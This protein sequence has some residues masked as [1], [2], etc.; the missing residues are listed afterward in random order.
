MP[1][2]GSETAS[3]DDGR[4]GSAASSIQELSQTGSGNMKILLSLYECIIHTCIQCRYKSDRLDGSVELSFSGT[5]DKTVCSRVDDWNSSYSPFGQA[6][7]I[8]G[9]Q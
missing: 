6:P 7:S 9:Q 5:E 3:A 4:T 1:S 8:I 2:S